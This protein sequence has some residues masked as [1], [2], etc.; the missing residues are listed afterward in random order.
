MQAAVTRS[1]K[2]YFFFRNSI[3]SSASMVVGDVICQ[4]IEN[5]SK[6]ID[7]RRTF[8]FGITGLFVAGPIGHTINVVLERLIP[9]ATFKPVIY[10]TLCSNF[11]SVFTMSCL[12]SSIC[13]LEGKGIKGCKEKCKRDIFPTWV[14]GNFVWIPYNIVQYLFVPLY[15]RQIVSSTFGTLWN[16]F[17]S[18]Q[19]AK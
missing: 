6:P 13:L 16:I 11:I 9:G 18:N 7:W 4:K 14:V 12:F 10:K 3:F 5:K 1:Q 17:L 2:I 19:A 8:N 15:M